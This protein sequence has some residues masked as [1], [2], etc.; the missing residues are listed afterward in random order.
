MITHDNKK[1]YFGAAGYSD[2][3][4]HKDELLSMG[5]GGE[6]ATRLYTHPH[7]RE[8]MYTLPALVGRSSTIVVPCRAC[9][10]ITL[11]LRCVTVALRACDKYCDT[12]TL[13]VAMA[14]LQGRGALHTR[15]ATCYCRFKLDD[16]NMKSGTSDIFEITRTFPR[17]YCNWWLVSTVTKIIMA[18]NQHKHST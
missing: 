4:I 15:R 1:V 10:H 3:T 11:Q 16:K 6:G 17:I 5:E 14:V 9:V 7:P 12:A 18:I 13:A 2:F 8:C